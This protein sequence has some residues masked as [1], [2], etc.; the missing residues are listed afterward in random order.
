MSTYLMYRWKLHKL[1]WI[2]NFKHAFIPR[3]FTCLKE[4]P[5]GFDKCLLSFGYIDSFKYMEDIWLEQ[6]ETIYH[7]PS[8]LC[9][10]GYVMCVKKLCT[11]IYSFQ[12]KAPKSRLTVKILRNRLSSWFRKVPKI[13]RYGPIWMKD[14][15]E[16]I[17]FSASNSFWS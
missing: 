1:V 9:F 4:F 3:T 6:L 7:Y 13:G 14:I 15:L 2:T 10:A 17:L 11:Y 8:Y 5:R 16:W 12:L